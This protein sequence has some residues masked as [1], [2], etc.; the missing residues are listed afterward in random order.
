MELK[1]QPP[2][3][4]CVS[5]FGWDLLP[6]ENIVHVAIPLLSI[7]QDFLFKKN[8]NSVEAI[9][10]PTKLSYALSIKQPWATLIISGIKKIEIR[11]WSTAIRGPV[12][13]HAAKIP[14]TR[15]E[16]W[17]LVPSEL[18]QTAERGGELIGMAVL[19]DCHIY[20]EPTD[21]ARDQELHRNMP[22]WFQLPCMFGFEFKDPVSI[23]P[24][25]VLGNVRF[26][27]V[28]L[29]KVQA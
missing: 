24:I 4:L 16:G 10:M 12:F 3:K 25:R 6:S 22:D 7:L 15:P 14:D 1:I 9:D 2:S 11:R 20:R 13:I 18:A 26:F 8:V 17:K 5:R 27:T 21:F 28:D 19:S 23:R 29:A